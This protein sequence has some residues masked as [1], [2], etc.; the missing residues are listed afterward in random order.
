MR[1]LQLACEDEVS[2]FGSELA[3]GR[4]RVLRIYHHAIDHQ[5]P[6]TALDADTHAVGTDRWVGHDQVNL[7]RA[8]SG[9]HTL[10][11]RGARL[12][13]AADEHYL[14]ALRCNHGSE[15]FAEQSEDHQAEIIGVAP[16]NIAI[17]AAI[18]QGWDRFI[19][20]DGIFI[21]MNGFGASAPQDQLYKKFGITA[22]A[23]AT[24]AIDRLAENA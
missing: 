11:Q 14:R 7:K 3:R 24:A 23:A 10:L 18:R 16:V 20:R 21:G 15:L 5:A 1:A 22:E 13:V 4:Q 2:P 19:G 8:R 17:E 12:A 9:T 6:L